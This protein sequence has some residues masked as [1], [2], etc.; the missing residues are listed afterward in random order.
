VLA[1][2]HLTE[3]GNAC[4][5]ADSKRCKH[6]VTLCSWPCCLS[7][8]DVCACASVCICLHLSVCCAR[9]CETG[10]RGA[11]LDRDDR[12]GDR[13]ERGGVGIPGRDERDFGASR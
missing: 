9:M 1:A 6:I 3:A 8:A 2:A 11:G 12:Y 4:P 10:G 7:G 13:P 5:S